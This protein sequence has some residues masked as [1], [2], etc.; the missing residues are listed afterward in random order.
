MRKRILKQIKW[1]AIMLLT[2]LSMVAPVITH[3]EEEQPTVLKVIS[4]L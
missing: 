2:L 4:P 3:A 1:S